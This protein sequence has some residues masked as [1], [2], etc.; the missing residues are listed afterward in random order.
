MVNKRTLNRL[1]RLMP[2]PAVFYGQCAIY[3][4]DV[5]TWM[6]RS[7]NLRL[8]LGTSAVRALWHLCILV[9]IT[10]NPSTEEE[11]IVNLD[12]LSKDKL[13]LEE[14]DI[15]AITAVVSEGNESMYVLLGLM[16]RF[17]N[18]PHQFSLDPHFSCK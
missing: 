3:G 16:F 18:F 7:L 1:H 8:I 10:W 13:P 15:I 12:V 6:A 5:K 11:L 14:G 4:T 9:G 17:V 2:K